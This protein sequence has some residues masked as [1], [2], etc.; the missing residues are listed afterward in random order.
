M[1]HHRLPP[2]TVVTR[3]K[4]FGSWWLATL[5]GLIIISIIAGHQVGVLIYKVLQITLALGISYAADRSL[6]RQTIGIDINLPDSPLGA[7]R[8]IARAIVAMAIILGLT[9]GI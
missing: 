6:F 8:L 7:A 4:R 3:V 1:K 5:I 9:L 2:E